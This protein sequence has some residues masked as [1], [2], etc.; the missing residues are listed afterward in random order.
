M[1]KNKNLGSYSV[2]P[3]TSSPLEEGNFAN[4]HT[5]LTGLQL[6]RICWMEEAKLMFGLC[7][8]IFRRAAVCKIERVATNMNSVHCLSASRGVYEPSVNESMSMAGF[9]GSLTIF[10]LSQ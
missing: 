1:R 2:V 8:R 3:R 10:L 6:L 5:D 4:Y 9:N 7:D